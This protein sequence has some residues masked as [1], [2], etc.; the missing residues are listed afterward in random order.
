MNSVKRFAIVM[1]SICLALMLVGCKS[2]PNVKKQKFLESG[3]RYMENKQF[4][5]AAIQYQNAIQIDPDF[6]EAHYQLAQ[7]SLGMT[8]WTAALQELQKTVSLRPLDMRAQYDLGSLYLGTRNYSDAEQIALVMLEKDPNNPDG[9]ALMANIDVVQN[10]LVEARDEFEKALQLAPNKATLQFNIGVF[11][12]RSGNNAEAESRLKKAIE[13]DPKLAVARMALADLYLS[14]HNSAAVEKTFLDGIATDPKNVALYSGLARFYNSEKR[15]SEAEELLAKVSKTFTADPNGYRLLGDFY[16]SVGDMNKALDEFAVL[17]QEHPKDTNTRTTYVELLVTCNRFDEAGQI[18]NEV[19]K[20]NAK[21]SEAIL[22]KALLLNRQGKFAETISLL[23]PNA[24]DLSSYPAAHLQMGIARNGLGDPTRAEAEWREAVQLNPNLVEGY[25]YLAAT[26][27]QRSDFGLLRSSAEKLIRLRPDSPVGFTY[28]AAAEAAQKDFPG[29]EVDLKQAIMLAPDSADGYAKM[30]KLR[31]LQKRYP[32]AEKFLGLALEKDPN[33]VEALTALLQTYADE[34]QPTTRAISRIKA[35]IARA[36]NKG[37]FWTLLGRTQISAGDR[38]SAKTSLQHAIEIDKGD[39][40]ALTLL[41]ETET[42]LGSVENAAAAYQKLIDNN[43][44]S[45]T[46]LIL[47][48]GLEQGRG[49]FDRAQQLYRKALEIRPNQPVA[50][51]NLA[52]LIMERGGNIDVALS[53]AQAARRGMPNNPSTADTLGWAY[54]MKGLYGPA[55]DILEDASNSAPENAA[56]HYHLAATYDKI[57]E[58][59]KAIEH[60]RKA[61]QL[62]PNGPNAAAIRQALSSKRG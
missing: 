2:D 32:E 39:D 60:Y 33:E 27:L 61:L 28:R 10:K 22:L 31:A 13:L 40:T 21:D 51:N 29:A 41:A 54:Y 9:H 48:A 42:S 4:N 16:V 50:A 24:K 7:A 26:G 6:A 34:K 38:N 3:N 30:G 43:P 44:R 12:A 23:E 49:N 17:H 59:S 52:F 19:L 8:N 15:R 25:S 47:L 35:Q 11:E 57:S 5:E 45:A 46:P 1:V 62:S 37:S 53:L 18:I 36:P 20:G 56:I 14:T 58:P 55:R